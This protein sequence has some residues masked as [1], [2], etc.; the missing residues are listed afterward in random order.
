MACYAG[1]SGWAYPEWR[2]PFYPA[3]TTGSR[4]LPHYALHFNTVEVNNTFY[5]M[6]SADAIAAWC[7]QVPP[8]FRFSFKAHRAI[9]HRKQFAATTDIFDR[10]ADLLAVVGPRL[11][12]VL[13]QFDTI[14]DVDQLTDFLGSAK[15]R[16]SRVA[17]EFRHNSW[18]SEAAFDALRAADV[19]LC[20]TETDDG[21]SHTVPASF[22]YVR[23]RRTTYSPGEL[24]DRLAALH[25]LAATHDVYAYLKHDVENAV[26]LRQ[27]SPAPKT[28]L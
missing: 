1:L 2:G 5:R 21:S 19:A 7:D 18:F 14:A 3:G 4:M 12:P 25:S 20:R 24:H 22:S 8:D 16:F 13:F 15:S 17:V 26:L 6:P 28:L 11:G 10:F 9:T 27:A 23:L